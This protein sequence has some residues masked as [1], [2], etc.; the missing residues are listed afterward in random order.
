MLRGSTFEMDVEEKRSSGE[1]VIYRLMRF[2]I[3]KYCGPLFFLAEPTGI[4]SAGGDRV[5]ALALALLILDP[6]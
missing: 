2:A 5:L 4:H 3:E 1:F 6:T